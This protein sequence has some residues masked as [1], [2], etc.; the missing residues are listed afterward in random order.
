MKKNSIYCTYCRRPGH[1]KLNLLKLKN[2]H[3]RNSTSSNN[4]NQDQGNFNSNDVAFAT[5]LTQNNFVSDIWIC[6][7]GACG[8]YCQSVEGLTNVKEIN[9]ST[10][11]GDGKSLRATKLGDLKCEVNQIDGRK[12]T[13]TLLDVKYVPD[14]YI[15]LFSLNKALKNGFKFSNE[16]IPI[17]L[18]KGLTTL[19]FHRIIKT[20]NDIVTGVKLKVLQPEDI[21]NG[22]INATISDAH[23]I[24]FLHKAL[25][26][27]GLET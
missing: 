11:N 16:V 12:F 2:K 8:H 5:T 24:D 7:S 13:V 17:C 1:S 25:R 10:T 20:T 3:N 18:I 22:I 15:S 14:L 19:M 21:L 6:D 23:E 26:H 27:C 9:K 4:E